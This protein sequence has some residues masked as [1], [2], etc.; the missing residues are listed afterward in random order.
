MELNDF[1]FGYDYCP[2]SKYEDIELNRFRIFPTN[3]TEAKV[4]SFK[5]SGNSAYGVVRAVNMAEARTVIEQW[6]KGLFHNLCLKIP[7]PE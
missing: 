5:R 6:A 1:D 3:E 2:V 4:V 7:N